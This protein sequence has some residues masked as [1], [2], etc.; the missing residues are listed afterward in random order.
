MAAKRK[1]QK[2][3]ET[4]A[5]AYLRVS[6]AEQ[7]EKELSLPA[8]Q[9]AIE[10]YSLRRE[11]EI[12]HVFTDA[13]ASGRTDDGR[14]GLR[15]MLTR[16]HEPSCEVGLILVYQTSRFMRDVTRARVLK[17]ALRKI[18]VRVIAVTQEVTND[19]MGQLVEGLFELID[20]HESDVNGMR[21][22]ACM[23]Q[24]ARQ[25]YWVAGHT[26]YGY[27]SR[28]IEISP[29]V[30]RTLLEP[31][32]E[33]AEKLLEIC[34][35]VAKG[36]G[37]TTVARAMN[38]ACRHYRNGKPWTKDL[39]LRVTS[40]T[41]AIGQV[42]YGRDTTDPVM[43]AVE[44]IVEQ[45]LWAQ[46]QHVRQGR[47]S[48]KGRITSSPQL[49][50]GLVKC[51][52]CGA[53]YQVET[54]GKVWKGQTP[55][56]YYNCR[57][58]CRTGVE[59]CV[60][61]R[62]REHTLDQAVLR[63]LAD[64]VFSTEHCFELLAAVVEE[65]GILKNR[66]D[67]ERRRMRDELDDVERRIQGWLIEVEDGKSAFDVAADRIRDLK[68]RKVH[69]QDALAKVSPL[70]PVPAVLYDTTQVAKFAQDMREAFLGEDRDLA[71]SYLRLLVERIDTDGENVE[72]TVR[73]TA[74]AGTV[75]EA[76]KASKPPAGFFPPSSST[77]L[78]K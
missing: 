39:V 27:R 18:G 50:A 31:D 2:R 15:E 33:E 59:A 8:Q 54:S 38:G 74:I 22:R 49:L 11:I 4:L 77:W 63:H 7:A 43:I 26:P 64:V 42:A 51:R 37:A 35:M 47:R 20:Q 30:E 69:L 68:Q 70:Q 65:T 12:V 1:V 61:G 55:Y 40:D 44:P 29:N 45:E 19:P 71:K 78:R 21:T 58:H 16:L 9:R 52:R 76:M 14:P 23:R 57:S 62:I 3:N 13:G 6:T 67:E 10:E 34:R 32:P 28:R 41:A 5:V 24:A 36:L 17:Q 72:I 56:R 60:G 53:A 48:G 46:V 66:N 73:G 25:G 75:G